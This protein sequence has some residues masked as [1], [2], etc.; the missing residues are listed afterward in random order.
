MQQQLL[1]QQ[2]QAPYG[3]QQAPQQQFQ[4]GPTGM[5]TPQQPPQPKGINFDDPA[6][7]KEWQDKIVNG[8]VRELKSFVSALIQQEGSQQV[9]QIQE[10]LLNQVQPLQQHYVR[11]AINQYATQK[12]SDPSFGQV[13]PFFERAVE[14]A[15]QSRPDLDLSNP[16]TMATIEFVARQQAQQTA[17]QYGMQFPSAPAQPA[18]FMEQPG[19]GSSLPTQAAPQ[20][21]P[22]ELAVARGFGMTPQQYSSYKRDIN[23]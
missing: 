16:T 4:T 13:R 2:A 18:P 12:A 23:G 11:S 6:T 21:T 10:Q 8:G 5:A 22:A 1:M 9:R 17:Q 3:M 15:V 14:Y 20:L 19:A 7:V